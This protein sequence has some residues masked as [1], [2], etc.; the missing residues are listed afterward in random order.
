METPSAGGDD[1]GVEAPVWLAVSAAWVLD[2]AAGAVRQRGS[3]L[4]GWQLLGDWLVDPWVRSSSHEW[5]GAPWSLCL[6]VMVAPNT[7]TQGPQR[8]SR[9]RLMM[10]GSRMLAS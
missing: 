10:L 6:R 5:T 9:S 4:V 7:L 3:V 8:V 1:G 2:W